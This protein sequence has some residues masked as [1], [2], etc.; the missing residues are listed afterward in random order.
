MIHLRNSSRIFLMYI[1]VITFLIFSQTSLFSQGIDLPANQTNFAQVSQD[2]DI[3]SM[4]EYALS[5]MDKK[6]EEHVIP[7]V[8]DTI[9]ENK[10]RT[11]NSKK[12]KVQIAS[13]YS[14]EK[15]ERFMEKE[16]TKGHELDII[17]VY[18]KILKQ[19]R[20]KVVLLCDSRKSALK[21]IRSKNYKG[22]YI[23][24]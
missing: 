21:I 20:Y 19:T 17:S 12:I 18:L 22:A 11:I 14:K 5:L 10:T 9:V 24:N 16:K 13:F 3:A 23:L 2:K 7:K 1:K 15:A 4:M 8:K 6:K